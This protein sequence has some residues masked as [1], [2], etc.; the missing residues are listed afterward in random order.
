MDND[1]KDKSNDRKQRLARLQKQLRIQ[2]KDLQKV[3][4]H[5]SHIGGSGEVDNAIDVLTCLQSA[6][7]NDCE[8]SM[9]IAITKVAGLNTAQLTSY[10]NRAEFKDM[11]EYI[12]GLTSSFNMKEVK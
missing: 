3:Q 11:V 10:V 9:K 8:D 4:Q 12:D 5:L 2:L 7:D 1:S 6:I